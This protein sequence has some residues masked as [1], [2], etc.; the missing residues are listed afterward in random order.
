MTF[1]GAAII[2]SLSTEYVLVPV[3]AVFDGEIFDPT[4]DTV[5]FAFTIGYGVKPSV[6]VQGYWDVN[7]VQG[8]WYNAKCLVGPSGTMLAAGTYTV[9]VKITADPEIPVRQSGTLV[10]QLKRSKKCH[11]DRYSAHSRQL[12]IFLIC[13]MGRL[14]SAT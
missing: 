4:G 12:I 5:Q 9:W 3:N 8:I 6:W 2:S 13:R 14:L 7:P 1:P 10:V 11:Q